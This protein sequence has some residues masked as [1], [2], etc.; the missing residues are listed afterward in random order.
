VL[1][2]HKPTSQERVWQAVACSADIPLHCFKTHVHVWVV[3]YCWSQT[4]RPHC[5]CMR[6][7][8]CLHSQQKYPATEWSARFSRPWVSRLDV[9]RCGL[10]HLQP[11]IG[12]I[13]CP[14]LAPRTASFQIPADSK[15]NFSI[16]LYITSCGF[17]ILLH[18]LHIAKQP[19]HFHMVYLSNA[20]IFVH[21]S[22]V[23]LSLNKTV[24]IPLTCVTFTSCRWYG[25]WQWSLSVQVHCSHE[26]A[27]NH[28]QQVFAQI[29]WSYIL[30]LTFSYSKA[31][32]I[33]W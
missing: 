8:A 9:A 25:T 6:A 16:N 13:C 33:K 1:S 17:P 19:S 26:A 10:V 7:R 5:Y 31:F 28:K 15:F 22:N 3:I 2:E 23:R 27:S 14:A 20:P 18:H 24:M 11:G 29:Y 32:L 4:K 21:L 30:T 12:K